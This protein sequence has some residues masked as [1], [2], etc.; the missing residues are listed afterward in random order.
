MERQ[1]ARALDVYM[2]IWHRPDG[3]KR[4]L[5]P[6]KAA[7]L[8]MI[9]I[10]CVEYCYR[11][12]TALALVETHRYTGR[13]KTVKVLTGLA[14]RAKVPAYRVAYKLGEDNLDIEWFDVQLLG[15]PGV[16]R[17]GPQEFADFLWS[18]RERH[19]CAVEQA[20]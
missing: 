9:D 20:A 15:Q 5:G 14:K 11:C 2:D 12:S 19:E 18:L 6:K 13:P 17:L 4:F 1:F 3:I 7:Q 16:T 10:D 8:A